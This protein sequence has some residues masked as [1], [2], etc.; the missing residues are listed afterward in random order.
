MKIRTLT[1][2]A[3]GLV[4][5]GAVAV[6]LTALALPASA[7]ATPPVLRLGGV[8]RIDTAIKISQDY[9]PNVGAAQG[10]AQSVVLARS[11]SFPDALA[12]VPLA[13]AKAGPLLLTPP[14]SLDPRVLT[15]IQRVL[16]PGATVYLMGGEGALSAAVATG[17]TQA[18]YVTQRFA[19]TDRF[20]TALKVAQEIVGTPTGTGTDIGL[21]VVTTG[22]DFPDALAAGAYAGTFG[23]AVVLT[24]GPLLPKAVA[25]YLTVRKADSAIVAVGGPAAKAA[26]GYYGASIVGTNRYDTAAKLAAEF[27]DTQDA[28]FPTYAG[29]A[30]GVTFPDAL[31]GGA[32]LGALG[33]PL[34]LTNPTALSPE[35]ST[36]LTAKAN[37][38]IQQYMIFGGTGAV[39][40]GVEAALNKMF[41]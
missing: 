28:P 2:R 6:L 12:G 10:A 7:A 38:P 40:T 16:A 9:V 22:T 20:D 8:D 13:V 39:G 21:V 33:G 24:A 34:L 35:A 36:Y 1:R 25:D 4:P 27:V 31:A 14:G 17:V 41:P 11:D 15:E 19:G 30:S 23:G 37:K 26:Q 5:L 3:A 18:G 29:V 32:E